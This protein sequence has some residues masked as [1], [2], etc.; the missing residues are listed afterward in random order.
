MKKTFKIT[1]CADS[2]KP[3]FRLLSDDKPVFK[4]TAEAETEQEARD[5]FAKFYPMAKL[6]TIK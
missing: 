3:L 1:Y 6:L 2:S 5:Y 4:T